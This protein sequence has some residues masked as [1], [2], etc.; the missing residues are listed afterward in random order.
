MEATVALERQRAREIAEEYRQ[1]GYEVVEAPSPEHLPDF[2]AG[3]HP[4]L[5]IRKGEEAIVVEVKSRASLAHET[6]VRE[7][8]RLLRTTPKPG[9]HFELIVV[10][11]AE[12]VRA[13]A[14]AHPFDRADI[15]RGL[16]AAARLQQAGFAEAALLPAWSA[17]EATVRL[18]TEEEGLVLERSEPLALLKHAAMHGVISRE[19]Y[20]FFTQVMAHRN[21][22]VHGFT[23]MDFES[24][25]V[26]ELISVTQRLLQWAPTP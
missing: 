4:D 23:P 21:A 24:N 10:G 1:R 3:Y 9:W 17:A 19:E 8:A 15:L 25:L 12:R 20:H 6:H 7:L 11:E 5:L 2:L 22:L 18:L 14:G 26:T 13:P 16:E